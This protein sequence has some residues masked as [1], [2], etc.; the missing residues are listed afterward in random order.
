MET[1]C[2]NP[3]KR[4]FSFPD[5]KL[6][7]SIC[8]KQSCDLHIGHLFTCAKIRL[9]RES[10][11]AWDGI[12]PIYA[13]FSKVQVGPISNKYELMLTL[14]LGKK[15]GSLHWWG[16]KVG[17]TWAHLPAIAE[18]G[19]AQL[20]RGHPWLAAWHRPRTLCCPSH[21]DEERGEKESPVPMLAP[22]LGDLPPALCGLVGYSAP[23][24]A[25]LWFTG[26]AGKESP[27]PVLV[28]PSQASTH[29]L[30]SQAISVGEAGGISLSV[31]FPTAAQ[32]VAGGEP[33]LGQVIAWR[34]FP[35]LAWAPCETWS[36]HYEEPHTE[37]GFPS[38][39]GWAGWSALTPVNLW[40]ALI[41]VLA[42][43]WSS[44]Y[45]G[46][47]PCLGGFPCPNLGSLQ[48]WS[49]QL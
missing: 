48:P 5:F 47:A 10:Q 2:K 19:R 31:G 16:Q 29:M 17:N 37:K 30:N 35:T 1:L 36:S 20:S 14:H 7:Y 34:G 8:E 3:C 43:N 28:S 21:G 6:K 4:S 12:H 26:G 49:W 39:C 9:S 44:T 22:Q 24:L 45:I 15:H 46:G 40:S 27:I 41:Q 13:V 25:S 38:P 42:L 33:R 32:N 23:P 11:K 18:P